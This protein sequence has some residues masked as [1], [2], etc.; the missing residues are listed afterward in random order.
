[1]WLDRKS[2]KRKGES[3]RVK[4]IGV[5]QLNQFQN[6]RPWGLDIVVE[7]SLCHD[8]FVV[9]AV[10]R[11]NS[12]NFTHIGRE[13]WHDEGTAIDESWPCGWNRIK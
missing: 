5:K 9:L 12:I 3:V 4:N 7:L 2:F 11:V 13:N 8:S 10:C 1:M 6:W